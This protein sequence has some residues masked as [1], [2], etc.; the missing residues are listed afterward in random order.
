MLKELGLTQGWLSRALNKEVVPGYTLNQAAQDLKN[1]GLIGDA[2][3]GFSARGAKELAQKAPA[4]KQAV[5]IWDTD[6]FWGTQLSRGVGNIVENQAKVKSYLLNMDEIYGTLGKR[7][8]FLDEAKDFAV[9]DAKKWFLDYD[10]LTDFERN[11]MKDVIPFYTWIRKNLANQ[12]SSILMY[13]QMYAMYPKMM[14]FA[15]MEDPNFDPSLVPEWQAEQSMF[16]IAKRDGQYMMFRPDLP[17]QDLNLIPMMFR[18]GRILPQVDFSEIKNDLVNAANP[19]IKQAMS[20]MTEKGYDFFRRKELEETAPAPYAVQLLVREPQTLAWLDNALQW[21]GGESLGLK[22]KVENG[23]LNMDAR[24]MQLI[25][26]FVPVL[27]Q[28]NQS[29]YAGTAF[30]PTLEQAIESATG[31]E[32]DYDKLEQMLQVIAYGTGLKTYLQD[33]PFREEQRGI[34]RYYSARDLREQERR[35]TPAEERAAERRRDRTSETIRRLTR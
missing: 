28:V 6:A 11:F 16:P 3:M 15:Q 31:I 10:D 4:W 12:M 18:E 24:L 23:K 22:M 29:I 17:F 13:P 34:S 1:S 5:G 2:S 20:L 7:P 32:D 27:R 21:A 35:L 33:Q 9:M 19:M 8:A 25:D 30:I 26:T 14:D